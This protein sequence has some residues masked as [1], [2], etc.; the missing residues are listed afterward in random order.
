MPLEN[1]QK[2]AFLR[3]SQQ[4]KIEFVLDNPDIQIIKTFNVR[5]F[6]YSTGGPRSISG[7][8]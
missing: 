7:P 3:I 8:S 1:Q 5:G 2:T 4:R 6:S